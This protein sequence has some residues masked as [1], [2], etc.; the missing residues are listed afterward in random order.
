M[1]NAKRIA[2]E[3]LCDAKNKG[4]FSGKKMLPSKCY[5][6]PF[7]E[8]CTY[9]YLKIFMGIRFWRNLAKLEEKHYSFLVTALRGFFIKK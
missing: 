7:L 8:G 9:F 4:G 6:K 3:G 5:K 1:R 2:A